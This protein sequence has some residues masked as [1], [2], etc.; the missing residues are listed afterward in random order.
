VIQPHLVIHRLET[1][2]GGRPG[3]VTPAVST[4]EVI[5]L[6]SALEPPTEKMPLVKDWAYYIMW[7]VEDQILLSAQ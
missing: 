3:A 5:G 1:A 2:G 6:S 7:V 4:I